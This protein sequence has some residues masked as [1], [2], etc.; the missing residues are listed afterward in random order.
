MMEVRMFICGKCKK[1]SGSGTIPHIV[2]RGHRYYTSQEVIVGREFEEDGVVIQ[3]ARQ[4]FTRRRK[5]IIGEVYLCDDCFGE[6]E[7]IEKPE[8]SGDVTVDYFKDWA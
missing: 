8:M 5:D 6:Y 7:E 1:T 2:P 4:T 3:S